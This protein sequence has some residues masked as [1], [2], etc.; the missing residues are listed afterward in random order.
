[1]SWE[2]IEIDSRVFKYKCVPITIFTF[3]WVNICIYAFISIFIIIFL[4]NLSSAPNRFVVCAGRKWKLNQIE[5]KKQQRPSL[6]L[7]ESGSH[8][9]PNTCICFLISFSSVFEAFYF[10]ILFILLLMLHCYLIDINVCLE[11]KQA[12]IR[13]RMNISKWFIRLKKKIIQ[14]K[15]IW[16][17]NSN[18][19]QS[20]NLQTK[21]LNRWNT[22]TLCC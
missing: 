19:M 7:S 4:C 14:K 10:H 9:R 12:H 11:K 15:D 6:L 20:T 13:L 16:K 17:M 2:R 5:K 22:T 21:A 18:R 8:D 1:M 3:Q